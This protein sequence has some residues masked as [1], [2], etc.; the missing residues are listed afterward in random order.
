MYVLCLQL[1]RKHV[2]KIRINDIHTLMNESVGFFSIW[3]Q[4]LD[5]RQQR[6][7]LV[8]LSVDSFV[9]P[10]PSLYLGANCPPAQVISM[11]TTDVW[12]N[13]SHNFGPQSTE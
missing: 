6:L 4:L 10:P 3:V 7:E 12:I 5:R 11:Q 1:C 8:L 13:V 9:E 2:L